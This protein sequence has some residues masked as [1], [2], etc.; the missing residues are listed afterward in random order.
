[1]FKRSIKR[2]VKNLLKKFNL[3]LIRYDYFERLVKNDSNLVFDVALLTSSPQLIDSPLV[4]CI[5]K[6]RSQIRQDIFVLSELNFKKNGF[7]VD[8]GATN[9]VDLSNSFLLEK[10]FGWNGILVEPARIWHKDLFKNRTSKI[11]T[12]CVSSKSGQVVTFNEVSS[13]ELSTIDEY[14]KSD[15]HSKFREKGSHYDVTT[16]SLTDLLDKYQAP[17]EIDYLSIDTEGS[18]FD[19]LNNFDF[20]K[21]TFSVITCEHN[22]TPAREKIHDLLTR[23]GY[24][25][26]YEEFSDFDDWYIRVR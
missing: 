23:N 15:L 7:F 20:N 18:E 1:M 21:Y 14:S 6:S 2:V 26:K 16:I 11:D 10:D 3:A 22:Y 24:Q 13:P 12:N 8:F 25:R 5:K 4:A 17:S 19:I 9:G